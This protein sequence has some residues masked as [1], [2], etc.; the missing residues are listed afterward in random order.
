MKAALTRADPRWLDSLITRR[1]PTD[2]YAE[3]YQPSPD[4][5]KVVIEFSR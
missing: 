5:I 2:S 3:A 1:V 4:D